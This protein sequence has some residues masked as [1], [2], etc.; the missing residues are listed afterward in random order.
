PSRAR[1]LAELEPLYEKS[2]ASVDLAF[3]LGERAKDATSSAEARKLAVR[4]AEVLTQAGEQEKASAAW[5]LVGEKF[6]A[7]REVLAQW[8]PILEALRKWDELAGALA[9]DAQLAPETERAAIYAR[10]GTTR[11]QKT[12]QIDEAIDAFARALA[13]DPAE[14]ASRAAL[15][16]L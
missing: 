3:V 9:S 1:A 4:A 7:S 2:G 6:G 10:L 14:K 12:K 8:L 16:K 11:W 15:E 5:K 13:I